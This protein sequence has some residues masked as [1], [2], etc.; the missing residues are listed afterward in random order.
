MS[1]AD[2]VSLSSDFVFAVKNLLIGLIVI[3][4]CLWELKTKPRFHNDENIFAQ[5]LEARTEKLSELLLLNEK[6]RIAFYRVFLS[7]S[8]LWSFFSNRSFVHIKMFLKSFQFQNIKAFLSFSDSSKFQAFWRGDEKESRNREFYNSKIDERPK[9]VLFRH[10]NCSDFHCLMAAVVGEKFQSL[11]LFP[12]Q[13]SIFWRHERFS[14]LIILNEAFFLSLTQKFN[15]HDNSFLVFSCSLPLLYMVESHDDSHSTLILS[16]QSPA[17][18]R[19]FFLIRKSIWCCCFL[20]SLLL[21]LF[22][23]CSIWSFHNFQQK[24]NSQVVVDA[25]AERDVAEARGNLFNTFRLFESN[26]LYISI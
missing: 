8:S 24:N 19:R 7:F 21:L 20:C 2:F 25:V 14:P 9:N 26:L 6:F 10:V 1:S 18:A 22:L 12:L 5:K 3:T 23:L 4:H 16:A 11:S 13:S 15:F 17:R